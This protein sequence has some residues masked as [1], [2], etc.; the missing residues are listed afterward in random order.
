MKTNKNEPTQSQMV[1]KGAKVLNGSVKDIFRNILLA[2]VSLFVNGFGVYLTIHANIGAAPWDVFNLGLSHTFGILYGTASITVSLTILLI[3]IL[4]RE[5]IGIAMFIDAVVVGKSVDFFNF[6]KIVPVPKTILGSVLMTFV[7]LFII[8]FT[9]G[10]YMMAALGCGPRDTLLV[11]LNKRIRKLPIGVVS[12]GLLSVVT[13]IGYLLGGPVGLG[14][15]LCAFFAGPIMQL[16]FKP[17]HFN[18]VEIKHQSLGES[19]H[20]FVKGKPKEA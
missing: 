15:I 2:A 13:L 7:G 10:T 4:M 14:T 17:L 19:F 1:Q 12:I 6:I 20:I 16:S 9:Q 5:P 3:D 11:G 18:A 8:G